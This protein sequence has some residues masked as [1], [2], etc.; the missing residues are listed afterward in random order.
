MGPVFL[1]KTISA[2]D[3]YNL[4]DRGEGKDLKLA[5]PRLS[6]LCVK[7]VVCSGGQNMGFFQL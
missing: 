2:R 5:I 7:E 4:V 1:N 3:Q 6:L